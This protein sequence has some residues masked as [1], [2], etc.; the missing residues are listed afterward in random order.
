MDQDSGGKPHITIG[1]TPESED[2]VTD[3]WVLVCTMPDGGEGVYGQ[4][5]GTFMV[6]FIATDL[7]TKDAMESYLR[8]HGTVEVCRRQ[9]RTLEWRHTVLPSEGEEIT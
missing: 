6:N 8:E 1:E 3:L 5:V 4:T 9:E 2:R 7:A